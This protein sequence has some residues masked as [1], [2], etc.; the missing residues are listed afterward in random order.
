[1]P[2]QSMIARGI[3]SGITFAGHPIGSGPGR[4]AR[5]YTRDQE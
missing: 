2:E 5:R 1:M 3:D 4:H